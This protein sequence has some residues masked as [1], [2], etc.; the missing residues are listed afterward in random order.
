MLLLLLF[1]GLFHYRLVEI[2]LLLAPGVV[3][4]AGKAPCVRCSRRLGFLP[5]SPRCLGL[6]CFLGFDLG[7]LPLIRLLGPAFIRVAL[8]PGL[9]L[10]WLCLFILLI[11]NTNSIKAWH[12]AKSR[13]FI[14]ALGWNLP[15]LK[16]MT[17]RAGMPTHKI[18]SFPLFGCSFGELFSNNENKRSEKLNAE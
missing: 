13:K 10:L 17:K 5:A 7:T 6:K 11:C 4:V 8:V 12:G 15:K 9:S 18:C 1:I 16:D 14:Q 3:R 2:K